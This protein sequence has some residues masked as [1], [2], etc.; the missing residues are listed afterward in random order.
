MSKF[1]YGLL[2][3]GLLCLISLSDVRGQEVLPLDHAVRTGKLPNG[4]TYYIRH[5]T[6]PQ[7]R[8]IM[9]LANKVGSVLEEDDQRGL[10]HFM[11]HMSF[12]GTRHFPKNE[13][14]NYLQK[15]GVR[16][17]ADINAY[18][19]FDE[20]VYELP[21]P[22]DNPKLV[23]NGIQIMRDWAQSA[24]LD[25]VEIDKERGVVLEEKRLGK[26]ASERMLQK[27]WPLIL[28]NSRYTNRIP[29]GTDEIL[30][31]F[32]PE[33]I[34][35]FYHDWYRP[36]LQA[37]IVVGDIDVDQMEK[38]VKAKFSDLKNPKAEKS[39]VIYSIPLTGKNQFISVT[40]REMT[41]TV[42]EVIIKHLPEKIKTADDYLHAIERALVNQLLASRF[43]ELAHRQDVPFL[44]GTAGIQGF[45]GGLNSYNLTVSAKSAELEKGFKVVWRENLR[46]S[47]LGFTQS[48]LDRAKTNYLGRITAEFKEKNKTNSLAYVKEYLQYFLNGVAAPGIE[49]ELEIVKNDLPQITLADIKKVIN[50]YVKNTD[51]DIVVMA[52]EKDK[53]GLPTEA[54]INKWINEVE[55]ENITPYKEDMNTAGLLIA[56]PIPG[57][58]VSETKDTKSGIT[59]IM[60]SN[61]VKV[62]LKPTDFKNN[63]ILFSGFASGGSSLYNDRD[64]E[65]AMAANV[66]PSFGAGNY[67]P[68]Q[69]NQYFAGKQFRV[70]PFINERFQGINGAS[71]SNDI[72]TALELTYA[73]FTEPIKD[74][75]RFDN[76]ITRSLDGMANRANDPKTV[77]Q[78]TINA[79]LGDH[80]PRKTGPSVAKVKMIDLERAFDIYHERFGNASG[81][82]FVFVGSI[83]TLSINPLVE[84]YLGSLPANNDKG[85]TSSLNI[86]TPS[87]IIERTVYKGTEQKASLNLTFSGL[88]DYS[89]FNK[90]KMEALKEVIQIRL[91]ER[92]REDESGV[93]SPNTRIN[94]TK[95]PTS[96][97]SL[98]IS[99]GCAPQNVEKLI[100]STLDEINKLKN[101]GP[102]AVNMEKFK[103]ENSRGMETQLETNG[104]WLNYV[105]AQLQ[106]NEDV[107]QVDGYF[108]QL[109][110]IT[111]SDIKEMAAQYLS[112][113]NYIRLVLL[114]EPNGN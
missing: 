35:R 17:G 71:A 37:L 70:Q 95:Y 30:N 23:Q 7:K 105:L 113:K 64:Y 78:D 55:S 101:D 97:Y 85:L 21:L 104:F 102:L 42:A 3:L 93:Y 5:N 22:S 69:L 44:S 81:F 109:K 76:I 91:L 54:V 31:N 103:A 107:N 33:T 98:T 20:T 11:E 84:K 49:A 41:G 108:T 96:K 57:K 2:A 9:Y 94:I 89:F 72:Q 16:F 53:A 77:F 48:E 28:N 32:K 56:Q 73:Y 12:N 62:L 63:E 114:P 80:N 50:D 111:P 34:R 66:V 18:T 87:G 14:V 74:P 27:Y 4:F 25:P 39:R 112:G 36:D 100:A 67:N 29:I 19:S 86:N 60:L 8:V 106:N 82:T 24:T 75:V 88:F 46:I 43:A 10:A 92:L 68:S 6:E 83:D 47:R 90:L 65:S 26:G 59:T 45:I 58:I 51:R 61:G 79:I 38:E 15:S 99:L 1:I 110:S 13:L 40:D 52:P